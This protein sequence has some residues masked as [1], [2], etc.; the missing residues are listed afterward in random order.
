MEQEYLVSKGVSTLTA[1]VFS[2]I[3][4]KGP[5]VLEEQVAI[6]EDLLW[7]PLVTHRQA[8]FRGRDSRETT[9]P[10]PPATLTLGVQ[11]HHRPIACLQ[12][13]K[14]TLL[15]KTLIQESEH[16]HLYPLRSKKT[17]TS[18][19]WR[20]RPFSSVRIQHHST[21]RPFN[22][23]TMSLPRQARKNAASLNHTQPIPTRAS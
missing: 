11:V 7:Q 6:R 1:R 14:P 3:H 17:A 21:P 16:Q 19:S 2:L 15:S 8:Q 5:L 10:D 12:A 4:K 23:R 20:C 9:T 22:W 18:N 13:L